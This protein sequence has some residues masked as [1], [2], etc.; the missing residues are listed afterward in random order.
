MNNEEKILQILT[1]LQQGQIE[2]NQRL[3]GM[4]SDIS[5]LKGDMADIKGDMS[6]LKDKV[7]RIDKT[8][9]RMQQSHGEKLSALFDGYT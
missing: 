6:E 2:T 1:E 9:I 4:E 5:G 7:D 8:A 3:D